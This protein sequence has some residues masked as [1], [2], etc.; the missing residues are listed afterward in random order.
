[1]FILLTVY[2]SGD[3][4]KENEI[5]GACSIYTENN[6]AFRVLMGKPKGK[7]QLGRPALRWEDNSIMEFHEIRWEG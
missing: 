5:V 2:Y 4:I 7:R 3:Q 6:N 1:V